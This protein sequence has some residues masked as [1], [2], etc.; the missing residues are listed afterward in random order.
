LERYPA[1][2]TGPTTLLLADGIAQAPTN[3][4]AHFRRQHVRRFDLPESDHTFSRRDWQVPVEAETVSF[5][6][7]LSGVDVARGVE[8]RTRA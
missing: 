7:R 4:G 8:Q 5:L 6:R 3:R 1:K 2:G